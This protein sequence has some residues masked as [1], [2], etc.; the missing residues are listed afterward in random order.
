MRN[1]TIFAVATG[2]GRSAI[3]V[4]RISGGAAAETLRAFSGSVPA[5]RAATYS[6]LRD[7]ATGEILDLGIILFFP[8][9]ASST[10]EDCAELHLHGGR[11]V[12]DGVL[13]A[14]SRSGLRPAEPGEFARRAFAN[15]RLDLSQVEALADLIDAQTAA[16][17]RQ[18]LRI[19]GGALRQQAE[20]W[21]GSLIETLALVESDLDFSD[22]GDVSALAPERLRA[23]LSPIMESMERALSGAPA[24]EQLREG[25]CVVILGRPNAG[26]STLLNALAGRDM[27]IVS[28]IPGT[29]RDMIEA[30]LEID[31]LPVTFVDTAGL[32]DAED[33]IERI[34]VKRVRDRAA[35]ADLGLWLSGSG[36]VP[37]APHDLDLIYVATK[38]DERPA[39]YG[40]MPICAPIGVGLDLLLA[41]IAVRAKARMGDGGSALLIRAR[42]REAVA[43]AHSS[44]VEAGED[45]PPEFVAE[46]LRRAMRAIGRITG[47]VDVEEVLDAVFTRF[48]I[49]K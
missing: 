12:I 43:T 1:D 30:H 11:A 9:P 7:P 17:R 8:S 19:A 49:G 45:K 37:D 26:K 22:E 16:Q 2:A 31:G 13:T 21:R 47:E 3:A 48:C 35:S 46:D 23:H 14:L 18:A 4:V 15:G 10:G 20:Q 36:E 27:A 41:E 25:F 34:G 39:P 40:W 24:S 29:T 42:H 5:A 6:T 44:L 33:E 28:P 38:A 32:R